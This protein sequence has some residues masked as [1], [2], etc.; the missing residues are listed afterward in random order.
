MSIGEII[1]QKRK[2]KGMTLRELAQ[3]A[4]VSYSY[5]SNVENG[6]ND[7][8]YTFLNKIYS[9]LNVNFG[10]EDEN[11]KSVLMEALVKEMV[12]KEVSIIYEWLNLVNSNY[13]ENKYDV[14]K[15][16]QNDFED[17]R[18]LFIDL[19]KNRLQKHIK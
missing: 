14:D 2:E 12:E 3:V 10:N 16:I 13:C 19:T 11:C 17:I 4:G 8:T 15:A 6:K 1:K 7:P 5:L 9:A 18:S